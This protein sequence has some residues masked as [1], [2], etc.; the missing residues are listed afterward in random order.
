MA[1]L[2]TSAFIQ[3]HGSIGNITLRSVNGQI[4][5]SRKITSI[6]SNTPKQRVCRSSFRQ[7]TKL[8]KSLKL[9]IDT[10]FDPLKHGSKYNHFYKA[11]TALANFIKQDMI[12]D[13]P[14]LPVCM[15][16]N[17]LTDDTFTGRVLSARGNME[18]GANL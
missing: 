12:K 2:H 9:I 11:N 18:D 13:C 10:G 6:N 1:I 7:M 8:A 4:I 3:A 17:A 15:L 14:K 5:V 16:Y